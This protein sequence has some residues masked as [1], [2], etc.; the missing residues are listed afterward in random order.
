MGVSEETLGQKLIVSG[1]NADIIGMGDDFTV[2]EACSAGLISF[3]PALLECTEVYLDTDA[4]WTHLSSKDYLAGYA[5][6]MQPCNSMIPAIYSFG[7]PEASVVEQVLEPMLKAPLLPVLPGSALFEKPTVVTCDAQDSTL[8]C[9]EGSIL[10]AVDA[11]ISFLE[12]TE[13]VG[14][15]F[16]ATVAAVHRLIFTY[17]VNLLERIPESHEGECDGA[18]YPCYVR[19]QIAM[20]LVEG[21]PLFDPAVRI[22]WTEGFKHTDVKTLQLHIFG[23][24]DK[25][26]VELFTAEVFPGTTCRTVFVGDKDVA[27]PNQECV[28]YVIHKD[29]CKLKLK[30]MKNEL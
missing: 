12:E 9:D 27:D 7:C 24:V 15:L 14:A 20:K 6:F 1:F 5:K 8:T 16:S 13:S 2:G 18:T 19:F 23:Q 4:F 26:S 17:P 21:C 10:L 28:G 25:D 29:A 3:A 30:N 22:K 11:Q